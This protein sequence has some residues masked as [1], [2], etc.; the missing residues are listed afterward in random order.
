MGDKLVDAVLD[1][2]EHGPEVPE[3]TGEKIIDAA[4]YQIDNQKEEETE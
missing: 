2:L 3:V 1:V 4:I